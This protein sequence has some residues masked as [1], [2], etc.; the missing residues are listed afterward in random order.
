MDANNNDSEIFLVLGK[1]EIF[2][3]VKTIILSLRLFCKTSCQALQ[4]GKATS[5]L[6]NGHMHYAW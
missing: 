1:E 2:L 5:L 3:I 6:F 4:W